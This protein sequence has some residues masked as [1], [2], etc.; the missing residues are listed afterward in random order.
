MVSSSTLWSS[1]RPH[2]VELKAS[3]WP[4]LRA[5][6]GLHYT[7]ELDAL[8]VPPG[9]ITRRARAA[10]SKARVQVSEQLADD[11]DGGQQLPES[12]LYKPMLKFLEQAVR[13]TAFEAIDT[14]K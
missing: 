8:Q 1:L 11:N 5:V 14:H 9:D 6:G 7:G 4:E 13:S 12:L 10:K 3:E 2:S